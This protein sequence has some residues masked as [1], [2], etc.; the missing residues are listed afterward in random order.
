MPLHPVSH[1]HLP[2]LQQ[3]YRGMIYE[4]EI[5]I[6]CYWSGVFFRTGQRSVKH[7]PG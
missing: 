2:G 1:L 3:N 4:T 5:I 6:S 7:I